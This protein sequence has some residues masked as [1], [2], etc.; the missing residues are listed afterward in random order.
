MLCAGAVSAVLIFAIAYLTQSIIQ[1]RQQTANGKHTLQ[2][3]AGQRDRILD[4]IVHPVSTDTMT[5]L[6]RQ[7]I[8]VTVNPSG[9][10]EGHGALVLALI[11]DATAMSE[12]TVEKEALS[13]LLPDE[14]ICFGADKRTGE[15]LYSSELSMEGKTVMEVGLKESSLQGGY[16]DFGKVSGVQRF[17]VAS[18]EGERGNIYF[19]A[20]DNSMLRRENLQY[21]LESAGVY[22]CGLIILMLYLLRG[23]NE[24]SYRRWSAFDF[25]SGTD[26]EETENEDRK[27][28]LLHYR[29]VPR[30]S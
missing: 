6:E 28:A 9:D 19:Y 24:E 23:Y 18:E 4:R 7:M 5:G 27:S 11:P 21:G 1:M 3:L 2:L 14:T 30:T 26:D 25:K 15:I 13:M 22:I 17:V 8:G 12:E 29:L 20:E 16:M 10:D